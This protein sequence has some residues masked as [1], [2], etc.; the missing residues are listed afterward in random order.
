MV[1][2]ITKPQQYEPLTSKH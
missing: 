2:Y 1:D